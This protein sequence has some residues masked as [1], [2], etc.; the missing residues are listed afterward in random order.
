[1]TREGYRTGFLKIDDDHDQGG[2]PYHR[3]G[4]EDVVEIIGFNITCFHEE[5]QAFAELM[6]TECHFSFP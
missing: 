1:M 6:R 5:A 2:L 4:V 3:F